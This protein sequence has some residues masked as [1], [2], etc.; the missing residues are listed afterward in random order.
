[1]ALIFK[2]ISL[3][4]QQHMLRFQPSYVLLFDSNKTD[5]GVVNVNLLPCSA[6]HISAKLDI[7]F[8]FN[9]I[10]PNIGTI[11]HKQTV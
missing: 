10:I 8:R 3:A 7:I 4:K 2:S 11:M 5:T 6:L 9:I 1:M